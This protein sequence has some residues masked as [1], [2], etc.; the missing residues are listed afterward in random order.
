MSKSVQIAKDRDG[1][2]SCTVLGT[3]SGGHKTAKAAWEAA[4]G[5]VAVMG[6]VLEHKLGRALGRLSEQDHELAK[7][8]QAVA[9]HEA[10]IKALQVIMRD[11]TSTVA[12]LNDGADMAEQGFLRIVDTLTARIEALESAAVDS[13]LPTPHSTLEPPHAEGQS[14]THHG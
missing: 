13:A 4:L 2:F 9:E 5:F 14:P 1:R 11:M 3:V 6:A 12:T 10:R 7:A 8:R